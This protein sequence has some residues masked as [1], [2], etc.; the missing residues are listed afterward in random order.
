MSS[1]LL[2]EL[3]RI[4]AGSKVVALHAP[5]NAGIGE[6]RSKALGQG[7]E[8][9]QYR[10]YE[11]GD[12]LRHLDRHVYAR[13]GRVVVRQ[14]HMEQ[15]LRIT[16]LLDGSASMG[17]DPQVWQRTVEL[18]SLFG[19]AALNGGDQVRFCVAADDRLSWGAT[20]SRVPQLEREVARLA[21]FVPHGPVT[22]LVDVAMRSLEHLTAGGLLV[23]VSDWLVDGVEDALRSWRVRGQELVA[24]QLLGAET[25]GN[26]EAATGWVNLVDVETG[27]TAERRLDAAA[28]AQYRR[29]L[30]DWS[31]AVRSAVWNV[32]GRWVRVAADVPLGEGTVR[33]LRRQGLIT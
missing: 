4:L 5:A 14:F 10:D 6:R 15:R 33:A 22:S 7:M 9:A 19:L 29:E 30:E 12:D 26:A 32:E 2:A 24:V 1:A 25:A 23:V 27:A 18:A 16:V 31:E 17:H 20:V 8:F 11:P 13:H 3:R 21:A 28:W